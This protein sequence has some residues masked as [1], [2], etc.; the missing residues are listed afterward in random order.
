MVVASELGSERVSNGREHMS[1]CGQRAS[2]NGADGFS[3]KHKRQL[4]FLIMM[5]A[6]LHSVSFSI[7]DVSCLGDRE[8]R[9][10]LFRSSFLKI[11]FCLRIFSRSDIV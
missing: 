5:L 6:S 8:V 7:Y 11:R 10:K 2:F 3:R 9:Y 4:A 1:Q